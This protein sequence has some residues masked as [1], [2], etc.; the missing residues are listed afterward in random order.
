MKKIALID[1]AEFL[2]EPK[3]ELDFRMKFG[4]SANESK[5]AMRALEDYLFIDQVSLNPGEKFQWN[6]TRSHN[7]DGTMKTSLHLKE[8]YD[9]FFKDAETDVPD[10]PDEPFVW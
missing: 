1:I 9:D 10:S 7:T 6:S 3:T 4:L 8:D 5:N 2:K